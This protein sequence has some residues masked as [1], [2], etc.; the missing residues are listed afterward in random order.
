M[1]VPVTI[2]INLDEIRDD[3]KATIIDE[4]ME[5]RIRHI[6]QQ[7]LAKL[8]P[9]IKRTLRQDVLNHLASELRKQTFSRNVRGV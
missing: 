6:V 9:D 5:A 1:N 7:E 2:K 4:A 3:L 8:L